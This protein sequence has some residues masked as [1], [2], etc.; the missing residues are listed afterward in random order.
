MTVTRCLPVALAFVLFACAAPVDDD[1]AAGDPATGQSMLASEP[2]GACSLQRAGITF[3]TA[4]CTTCMQTECCG[5]TASCFGPG[6]GG[7]SKLHACL[8]ECPVGTMIIAGS[9]EPAGNPCVEA[10]EATHAASI[11]KHDT[12]DACIRSKC[13]PACDS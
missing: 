1:G 11:Q 8:L 7:C 12:Y 13:M 5:E 3:P 6:N 9:G 4:A 10:C 2:A